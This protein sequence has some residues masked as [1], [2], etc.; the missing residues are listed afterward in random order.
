MSD[1][2]GMRAIRVGQQWRYVGLPDLPSKCDGAVATVVS[3]DSLGCAKLEWG[4][5][6]GPSDIVYD[7]NV[8]MFKRFCEKIFEPPAQRPDEEPEGR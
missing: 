6:P 3:I 4:D 7:A 8:S 1:E 2:Y 5:V